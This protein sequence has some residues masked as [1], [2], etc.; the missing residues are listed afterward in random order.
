MEAI[1]TTPYDS[2]DVET[3]NLIGTF[4][5]EAEA[6]D[7]VRQLLDTNGPEYADALDLRS[8][9]QEGRSRTL[10]TGDALC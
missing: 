1:M 5:T 8:V 3:G 6:R 10:A 4:E 7:L 9:D 2:W